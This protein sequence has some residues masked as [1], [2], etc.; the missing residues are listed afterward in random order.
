MKKNMKII[1]T[2]SLL[3][4]V[5]LLGLLMGFGA[6]SWH[7]YPRQNMVHSRPDLPPEIRETIK[8]SIQ[9]AQ[10]NLKENREK[11]MSDSRKLTDIAAA[12]PFDVAAFEAAM[13]DIFKQQSAIEEYKRQSFLKV[14]SEL[15]AA[16][17]EVLVQHFV[18]KL[19]RESR[20]P[21]EFR[22][23]QFREHRFFEGQP[24]PKD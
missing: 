13:N 18:A 7:K 14:L 1:F 6:K 15:P 3:L 19:G 17:R 9:E 22:N 24:K 10:A 20:A 16:Q 8:K 5:L 11:L 23:N 12:E 4:N 2:I 21:G